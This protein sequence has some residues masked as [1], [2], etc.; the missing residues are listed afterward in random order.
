MALG[1]QM[2]PIALRTPL[3]EERTNPDCNGEGHDISVS[4][5]PESDFLMEIREFSHEFSH[6]LFLYSH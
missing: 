3:L 2:E 6:D 4:N 5:F 1:Q